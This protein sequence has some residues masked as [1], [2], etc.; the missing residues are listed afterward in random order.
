[1]IQIQIQNSDDTKC[2]WG[3]RVVCISW[4]TLKNF[5]RHEHLHEQLDEWLETWLHRDIGKEAYALGIR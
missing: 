1:M 4:Q 5:A 3:K 2:E